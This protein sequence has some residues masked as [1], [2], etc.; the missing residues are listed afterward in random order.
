VPQPGIIVLGRVEGDVSIFDR[1]GNVTVEVT[2][3]D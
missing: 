1:P 3:L 2:R